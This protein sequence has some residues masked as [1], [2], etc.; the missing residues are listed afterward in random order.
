MV[1]MNVLACASGSSRAHADVAHRG[2]TVSQGSDRSVQTLLVQRSPWLPNDQ[3]RHSSFAEEWFPE[4]HH[5]KNAGGHLYQI[6][7][8]THGRYLC[9]KEV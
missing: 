6:N 2:Q 7:R 9:E 4:S 5:H 8:D 3:A 1:C